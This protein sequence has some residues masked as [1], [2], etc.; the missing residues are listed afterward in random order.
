MRA[1]NVVHYQCGI[2]PCHVCSVTWSVTCS[3]DGAA[4]AGE[5]VEGSF[6]AVTVFQCL[7]QS[8]YVLLSEHD[9]DQEC[10]FTSKKM[11][12]TGGYYVEWAFQ[13]LRNIWAGW[14][15][16]VCFLFAISLQ[17]RMRNRLRW[18]LSQTSLRKIGV[19]SKSIFPADV[20][21][22]LC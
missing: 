12:L 19:T 7:Q 17:R 20:F 18:W 10:L 5:C 11:P 14:I 15:C 16:G 4:L 2:W 3:E 22:H 1:W 8:L 13:Y 21:L 9:T 6:C